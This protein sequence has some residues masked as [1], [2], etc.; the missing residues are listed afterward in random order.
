MSSDEPK[1]FHRPS[2]ERAVRVCD[3]SCTIYSI[4]RD[5]YRFRSMLLDLAILLLS[6]WLT[7]M[8]FV[9]PEIAE[10]LTPMHLGRELW[11][12]LL[13]VATFSLS[14]VQ[15]QVDWKGRSSA[16]QASASACS[17]FVKNLRPR[18]SVISE[19]DS[20]MEMLRYE[21]FTETLEPIPESQFL[22]LK[23]RHKLKVEMSRYLDR[24]PGANLTILHIRLLIRDSLQKLGGGGGDLD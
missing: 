15:L 22:R 4:L 10:Q 11:I 24:F 2:I 7:A 9:Q 8:A 6:A 18:I 1:S 5:R 23:Q 13:S 19:E 14:L 16:Y 20:K 3:Q 17:A 12:G 21:T